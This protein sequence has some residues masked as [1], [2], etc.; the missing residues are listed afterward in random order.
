MMPMNDDIRQSSQL[1]FTHGNQQFAG[2]DISKRW[3]WPLLCRK[4]NQHEK[5]NK[6]CPPFK[7]FPVGTFMGPVSGAGDPGQDP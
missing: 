4:K 1:Q 3:Q 7:Y 2:F 6:H 5:E